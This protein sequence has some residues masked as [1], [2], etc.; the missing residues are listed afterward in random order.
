LKHTI[1]AGFGYQEPTWSDDEWIDA[2]NKKAVE[3]VRGDIF[4]QLKSDF[5]HM[6]RLRQD[7]V[8]KMNANRALAEHYKAAL[9][10]T[11]EIIQQAR[12]DGVEGGELYDL[13]ENHLRDQGGSRQSCAAVQGDTEAEAKAGE[14]H[15]PVRLSLPSL[16]SLAHNQR[17]NTP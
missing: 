16:P 17:E 5:S 1:Y 9:Q 3:Y 10:K 15:A 13:L 12:E 11:F 7:A 6:H 8:S 4:N 2:D 14:I